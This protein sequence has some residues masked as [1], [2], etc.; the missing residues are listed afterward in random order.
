[1]IVLRTDIISITIIVTIIAIL[2]RQDFVSGMDNYTLF[3]LPYKY[4][5][6]PSIRIYYM[7]N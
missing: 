7:W 3:H 5:I 4:F 2:S 1:M 6:T